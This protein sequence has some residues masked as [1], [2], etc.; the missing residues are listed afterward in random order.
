MNFVNEIYISTFRN[1]T[2]NGEI[3]RTQQLLRLFPDLI[4]KADSGIHSHLP[5]I[6]ESVEE[7][8]SKTDTNVPQIKE[9]IQGLTGLI[10]EKN[11]LEKTI[12]EE[13][14]ENITSVQNILIESKKRRIQ[15]LNSLIEA[16]QNEFHRL[17]GKIDSISSS[18]RKIKMKKELKPKKNKINK[19]PGEF[20]SEF[21]ISFESAL[22]MLNMLNMGNNS[23]I[24][25]LG[26][27]DACI[28]L[29]GRCFYNSK[30]FS[31]GCSISEK[32]VVSNRITSALHYFNNQFSI[33]L[34][35]I[36]NSKEEN[37]NNHFIYDKIENKI[38]STYNVNLSSIEN[39]I[40]ELL[41]HFFQSN[42]KKEKKNYQ[43]QILKL[44]FDCLS[45]DFFNF[46][47]NTIQN[48][49]EIFEKLK[50][51]IENEKNEKIFNFFLSSSILWDILF[52][53]NFEKIRFEFI[54]LIRNYPH[55]IQCL[56][57]NKIDTEEYALDIWKYLSFLNVH[58]HSRLL[59]YDTFS[60]TSFLSS[61][62]SPM[63]YNDSF[64]WFYELLTRS[65]NQEE[66]KFLK[67]YKSCCLRDFTI[68]YPSKRSP[69]FPFHFA[70]SS[71]HITPPRYDNVNDDDD[72]YNEIV[73]NDN[74]KSWNFTFQQEISNKNNKKGF[75]I[76]GIW[77]MDHSKSYE[78]FP[79]I[80]FR[81][82][83]FWESMIYN[84]LIQRQ[85][86]SHDLSFDDCIQ[87]IF[88]QF[89]F[90]IFRELLT[91]YEGIFVLSDHPGRCS[92]ISTKSYADNIRFYTVE[93]K[94]AMSNA[95]AENPLSSDD[96]LLFSND[97]PWQTI[98]MSIPQ[99]NSS[100]CDDKIILRNIENIIID[101][102]SKNSQK[103]IDRIWKYCIFGNNEFWRIIRETSINNLNFLRGLIESQ[104]LGGDIDDI[105]V[106]SQ[107]GPIP[108]DILQSEISIDVL[109]TSRQSRFISPL[110]EWIFK[111]KPNVIQSLNELCVVSLMNIS[112]LDPS[113]WDYWDKCFHLQEPENFSK[114]TAPDSIPPRYLENL[115]EMKLLCHDVEEMA[116]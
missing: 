91:H 99:I 106:D 73:T 20:S 9:V 112:L 18:K 59:E 62:N 15:E 36:L 34:D 90:G 53:S 115:N 114:F 13:N 64:D 79:H 22:K 105:V 86:Q 44:L 92:I 69:I 103:S 101:P 17:T 74:L 39:N 77:N 46:H 1:L 107:I 75:L 23:I 11:K 6:C 41:L 2:A 60:M 50:I 31:Y 80:V 55:C 68:L 38:G 113:N 4:M 54:S 65:N 72:D 51:I 8:I 116:N 89:Q 5:R 84:H 97:L 70:I 61:E 56:I 104:Y 58:S 109:Q 27:L 43:K 45:S 82:R 48:I 24:I 100:H 63:K 32:K 94:D 3:G 30:I 35:E 16:L 10:E 78:L 93:S 88:H 66:K 25:T 26:T 81:K 19:I 14:T 37:K 12:L 102:T 95:T 87:W 29:A 96:I 42:T 57:V 21:V 49:E 108:A 33:I 40:K 83:K 67:S 111:Q 76:S 7:I 28:P 110:E 85:N 71:I 47:S 98:R 52:K